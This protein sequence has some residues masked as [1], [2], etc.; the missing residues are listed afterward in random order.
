MTRF[1]FFGLLFSLGNSVWAVGST[2]FDPFL[3]DYYLDCDGRPVEVHITKPDPL[4]SELQ[5]VI[6][7]TR[8]SK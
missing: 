8:M 4:K 1:I 5:V 2:T 3:G 7:R 6:P